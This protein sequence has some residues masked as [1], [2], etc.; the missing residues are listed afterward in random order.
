MPFKQWSGLL[1]KGITD[2]H[3]GVVRPVNDSCSNEIVIIN[4]INPIFT[5][6]AIERAPHFGQGKVM[7][8]VLI[9]YGTTK[10]LR[11]AADPCSLMYRLTMTL[12]PT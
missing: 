11:V 6:Q 9:R 8:D 7:T 4:F 2:I 1:D 5:S 12:V 10:N 3:D